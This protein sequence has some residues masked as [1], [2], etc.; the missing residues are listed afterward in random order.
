[1]LAASKHL[2]YLMVSTS[3]RAGAGANATSYLRVIS[4]QVLPAGWMIF[5]TRITATSCRFATS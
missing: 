1:V 2:D 3:Y 5:A 4:V